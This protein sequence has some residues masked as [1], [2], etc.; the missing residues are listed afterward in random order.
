ML[1]LCQPPFDAP[2]DTVRIRLTG[3]LPTLP[4]WVP[5]NLYPHRRCCQDILW[6]T[7]S[8]DRRGPELCACCFDELLMPHVVPCESD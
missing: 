6:W 8:A 7:S 5:M 3:V 1:R 2:R 4:D